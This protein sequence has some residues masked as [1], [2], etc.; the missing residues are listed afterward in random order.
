[1]ITRKEY[2][3][4]LPK[5]LSPESFAHH[6]RYWA[7]FVNPAIRQRVISAIGLERLVNSTD[8][9][10]NDIPLAEWDKLAG[11]SGRAHHGDSKVY[12]VPNW[13]N[14]EQLKEVGEGYS[15]GTG[16]CIAKEA[17]RQIADEHKGR[18]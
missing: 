2:I 6:R 10:L 16:V 4:T 9:Y 8:P 13:I 15:L 18:G 12:F 3:D 14:R 17:A 5:Y 1:M 11:G 7:Q